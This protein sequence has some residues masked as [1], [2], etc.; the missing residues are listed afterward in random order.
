MMPGMRF[1]SIQAAAAAA[2]RVALRFPFVMLAAVTAAVL[3][4]EIVGRSPS[5]VS[6]EGALAA[7]ALGLSLFTAL[8]LASERTRTRRVALLSG[9][10]GVAALVAFALAWPHWP[11]PMRVRRCAQLAL[12]FHLLVAFL[13]Y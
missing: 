8:A 3:G 2:S 1:P 13:P 11:Q 5:P 9:L 12:G 7:A 4:C 6:L 10:I